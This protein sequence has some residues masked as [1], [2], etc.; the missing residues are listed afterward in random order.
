MI[1]TVRGRPVS[2]SSEKTMLPLSSTTLDMSI[3]SPTKLS[4]VF[5][6]DVGRDTTGC[7][8]CG[9]FGDCRDGTTN[10]RV[11]VDVA[12]ETDCRRCLRRSDKRDVARSRNITMLRTTINSILTLE[13]PDPK[14]LFW[15]WGA[16]GATVGDE[17]EVAEDERCVEVVVLR[18]SQ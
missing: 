15:D 2:T 6:M 9:I 8:G 5:Q 11:S 18:T 7:S 13:N 3:S 12:P 17:D 10:I 14:V 4:G 16:V 1:S